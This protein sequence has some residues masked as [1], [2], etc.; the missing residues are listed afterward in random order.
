MEIEYQVSS[1]SAFSVIVSKGCVNLD[2]F[3]I[4]IIKQYSH[5]QNAH[6]VLELLFRVSRGLIWLLVTLRT[7]LLEE[8][9]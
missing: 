5:R 9:Q 6:L 2:Y 4:I 1:K 3:I 7:G 8:G